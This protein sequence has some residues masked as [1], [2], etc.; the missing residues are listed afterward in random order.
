MNK[1]YILLIQF[2]LYL[3][4]DQKLLFTYKDINEILDK[5]AQ[6]NFDKQ[7]CWDFFTKNNIL[8]LYESY[9]CV[10]TNTYYYNLEKIEQYKSYK[11]YTKIIELIKLNLD[12][13]LKLDFINLTI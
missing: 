3:S 4:R 11:N 1:D 12:L 5:I 2:D 13:D 6:T 9:S 7:F 10:L 8:T